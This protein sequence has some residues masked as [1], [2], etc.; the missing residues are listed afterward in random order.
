V[1]ELA[2]ADEMLEEVLSGR[3]EGGESGFEGIIGD[4]LGGLVPKL[5]KE[6][7]RA[8]PWGELL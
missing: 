4:I 2:A 1:E 3:P 6:I 7:G 5:P 8:L